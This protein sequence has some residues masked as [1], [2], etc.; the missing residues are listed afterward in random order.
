[1]IRVERRNLGVHNLTFLE[2]FEADLRGTLEQDCSLWSILF[3]RTLE[4]I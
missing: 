2:I 4:K 3:R 1:M